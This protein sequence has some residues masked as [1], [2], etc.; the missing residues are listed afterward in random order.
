MKKIHFKKI[1]LSFLCILYCAGCN[2]FL[3][4]KPPDKFLESQVF[5]SESGVHAALNTVYL[6]LAQG[7]LY[8]G[9]LTMSTVEVMAQ[10]YGLNSAHSS[11]QLSNYNYDDSDV[12]SSFE[13]IWTSGYALILNIN[14]FIENIETLESGQGII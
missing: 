8:G 13:G 12:Q 11:Y 4:V 5:S 1:A 10:R 7:N 14:D 6:R 9:Q 2:D 3:D